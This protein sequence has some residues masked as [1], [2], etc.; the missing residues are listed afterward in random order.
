MFST[1][2]EMCDGNNYLGPDRQVKLTP[3]DSWNIKWANYSYFAQIHETIVIGADE[4]I[5]HT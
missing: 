1:A 3:R 4:P 2:I 5:H